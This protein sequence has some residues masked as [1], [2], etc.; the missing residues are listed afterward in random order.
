MESVW[1][2]GV[3]NPEENVWMPRPAAGGA[4]M[5]ITCTGPDKVESHSYV[6][7][8]FLLNFSVSVCN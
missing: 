7:E 4:T 2:V 3:G 8:F 5:H 6:A 1:G